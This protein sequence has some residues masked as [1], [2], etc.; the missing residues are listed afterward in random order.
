MTC[1]IKRNWLNCCWMK[2]ERFSEIEDVNNKQDS[3]ER[4]STVNQVRL[5]EQKEARIAKEVQFEIPRKSSKFDRG[6]KDGKLR[7]IFLYCG[8]RANVG[9][10]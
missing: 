3:V 6:K 2:V 5:D 8:G 7:R 1:C 4:D 10:D 9:R